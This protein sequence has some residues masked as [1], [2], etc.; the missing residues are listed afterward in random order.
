MTDAMVQDI[1]VT[2]L[3]IACILYM[4]FIV[5]ESRKL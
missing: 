2:I 4:G 3:G 1:C 5:H